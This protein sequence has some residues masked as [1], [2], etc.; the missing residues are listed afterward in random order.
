MALLSHMPRILPLLSTANSQATG[1]IVVA[2]HGTGSSPFVF[3]RL[4]HELE[5]HGVGLIAPGYGLRATAGIDASSKEVAAFLES[6][7]AQQVDIVGHSYGALIGL[8][9]VRLSSIAA[10]CSTIV[11]LGASWRGTNGIARRFPPRLVRAVAGDSFVELEHFREEPTAPPGT[12]IVSIVSDTDR[13]VPAWSSRWGDVIE[14]SGVSHAALP[15]RTNEIL[16]ALKIP[17]C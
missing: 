6:L 12:D 2:L 8:R 14:V 3:R 7:T 17:H 9:A 15:L 11:G 4:A 16:E 13:I 5:E 1:R 10:R